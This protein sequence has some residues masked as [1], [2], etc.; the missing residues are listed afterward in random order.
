VDSATDCENH[1]LGKNSALHLW[2]A[3]WLDVG[4]YVGIS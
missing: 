2:L 1:R 3:T 4:V